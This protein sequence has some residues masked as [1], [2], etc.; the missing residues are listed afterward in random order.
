MKLTKIVL[1]AS[2]LVAPAIPFL[3]MDAYFNRIET[4]CINEQTQGGESLEFAKQI[5][6]SL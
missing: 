2:F 3:M 4:K 1:F 5:C 6:K